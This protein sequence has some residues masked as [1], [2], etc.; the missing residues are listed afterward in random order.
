MS[1]A[2]QILICIFTQLILFFY[3]DN[4]YK[5]NSH[6]VRLFSA[7]SVSC[8]FL[9]AATLLK[10]QSAVLSLA[11]TSIFFLNVLSVA[12]SGYEVSKKSA[13]LDALSLS[14][15]KICAELFSESALRLTY[16]YRGSFISSDTPVFLLKI[17]VCEILFF[18][19]VAIFLKLGS[20]KSDALKLNKISSVLLLFP[21]LSLGI[22]ASL[23]ASSKKSGFL[24]GVNTL[25]V[26]IS[27]LLLCANV[28]LFIVY[29]KTVAVLKKNSEYAVASRQEALELTHY[30]ELEKR[31]ERLEKLIHETKNHLSTVR[32][33][34]EN[35]DS[36]EISDYIESVLSEGGF[37]YSKEYSNNKLVNIIVSRYSEL[38]EKNGVDFEAD[39]RDVP[40]GSMRESALTS[41]L[42]NILKNAYEAA[43]SSFEKRIALR[44]ELK[45]EVVLKISAENSCDKAPVFE[46]DGLVS[47]KPD[48][49]GHGYG[50]KIISQIA[51]D[52]DGTASFSYDENKR[53][54]KCTVVM[55]VK[56]K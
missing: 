30:E 4:K 29:E 32:A 23:V 38:C 44:I 26:L 37:D 39:I 35:G 13:V 36:P 19:L 9:T 51:E 27:L 40:F 8:V 56:Q 22:I 55:L 15:L 18:A 11:E 53:L 25:F 34:A 7:F 41:L 14:V 17:T 3:F 52:Y 28:V 21:F 43:A 6:S 42:D 47:Q 48:K 50:T 54:F 16:F 46:K 10:E 49:A 33:L 24:G 12:L 5:K 1:T 2:S 45:N 31:Q 20:F